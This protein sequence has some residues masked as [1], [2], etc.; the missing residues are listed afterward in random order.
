MAEQIIRNR[1]QDVGLYNSDLIAWAEGG[2]PLV[3]NGGRFLSGHF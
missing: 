3:I 1:E 2:S